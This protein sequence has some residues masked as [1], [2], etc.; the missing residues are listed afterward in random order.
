MRGREKAREIEATER[1]KRKMSVIRERQ[2]G[3]QAKRKMPGSDTQGEKKEREPAEGSRLN[4]T[5]LPSFIFFEKR[6]G[7]LRGVVCICLCYTSLSL[8]LFLFLLGL[9]QK[10]CERFQKNTAET[11]GALKSALTHKISKCQI[12]F[13]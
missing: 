2:N 1:E 11:I 7:R 5:S 9:R 8:S 13:C 4:T 12:E 6:D 3:E 10:V